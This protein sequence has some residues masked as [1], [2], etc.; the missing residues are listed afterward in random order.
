MIARISESTINCL[1]DNEV[2]VFGSN[3]AGMHGAGAA[4]QAYFLFGAEYRKGEGLYGQSYAIPTKDY[5]I[6]TLPLDR[7]CDYVQRFLDFAEQTPQLD[8][9][10]TQIGCGYAGYQPTDIAPMF[11][12]ALNME[13]V[14]LPKTFIK[15]LYQL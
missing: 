12:R 6:E 9:L 1:Y 2:F 3:E 4:K 13:N 11:K 8:F 14:F 10:V 5:N 7:I 15:I